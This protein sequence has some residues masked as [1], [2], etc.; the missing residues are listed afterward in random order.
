M[1]MDPNDDNLFFTCLAFF[2]LKNCL[3]LTASCRLNYHFWKVIHKPK[4]PLAK[5]GC[6]YTD[7]DTAISLTGKSATWIKITI[8]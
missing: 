1:L 7:G 2:V 8:L 3:A 4:S 6:Y 5:N